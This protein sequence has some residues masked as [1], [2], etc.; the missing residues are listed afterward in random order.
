MLGRSGGVDALTA[1]S[2]LICE[3]RSNK[4]T[5]AF[6]RIGLFASPPA[7]KS[8][9]TVLIQVYEP[10]RLQVSCRPCERSARHQFTLPCKQA[11][12]SASPR[13]SQI[14]NTAT[15]NVSQHRTWRRLDA[16]ARASHP[17]TLF[18]LGVKLHFGFLPRLFRI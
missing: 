13:T 2:H 1:G 10:N 18:W 11:Q 15:P 9:K 5:S 12:P 16:Y 4:C 7:K 3:L 8:P 6:S 17:Q 14:L